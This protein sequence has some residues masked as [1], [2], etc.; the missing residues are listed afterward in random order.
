MHPLY[1]HITRN[2]SFTRARFMPLV[3]GGVEAGMVHEKVR[4]AL[5]RAR[6]VAIKDD[7]LVFDGIAE[8]YDARTQHLKT[9]L[10]RLIADR[11]VAKER[12]ELYG[13][14]L[15][16]RDAP[17]AL[18]DR[19]LMPAMGFPAIGI[20]CNAYVQK[21]DGLYLW[22]ARR[23]LTSTVDPGKLDHLVAGGQPYGLS[24]RD[25]LAKEAWEEAAI[26]KELVA[27]AIS[28][29]CIRY[30]KEEDHG[31]RRDTLF[32]FDLELPETFTPSSN[33]GES[34]DFKLMHID[35]VKDRLLRTDDFKFNVP[36][37]LI[38]F[39]VR[40]GFISPEEPGYCDITA[41][42]R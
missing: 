37:V 12:F 8:T 10:Q 21:S 35:D 3:L 1:R 14:A 18:A 5:L 42:L 19:G 26:P 24:L 16:Y 23:S 13:V 20:H 36:L 39:M 29:G 41:S 32:I 22:I 11:L 34:F 25:N 17:L 4:D 38:D 27:N 2:N 15:H 33:D 6:L 9:I 40:R 31:V 30:R 7:H 28:T